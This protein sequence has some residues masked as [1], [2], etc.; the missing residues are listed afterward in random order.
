MSGLNAGQ[1]DA[2]TITAN[3]SGSFASETITIAAYGSN[4][5]G[6]HGD[7]SPIVVTVTAQST[8]S[9]QTANSVA[10]LATLIQEINKGGSLA[11]AN[12]NTAFI[13]HLAANTEYDLDRDFDAINLDAGSSLTIVGGE[14]TVINGEDAHH[15]FFL[16]N[17]ALTLRDLTLEHLTARGGDGLSAANV[18]GGGGA[19]LGGA[20][21]IAGSNPDQGLTGA[22]AVLDN[23]SFDQNAAVGGNGGFGGGGNGAGGALDGGVAGAGSFGQGG[24]DYHNGSTQ[25]GFGGGGGAGSIDV[26]GGDG[27][28]GGGGGIGEGPSGFGGYGG[29]NQGGGFGG[30]Q[31]QGGQNQGGYNPGNGGFGGQSQ[32]GQGGYNGNQGGQNQSQPDHDP[33]GSAPDAGGF[34][35]GA[36]DEPPF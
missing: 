36:G 14:G 5:S 1:S 11:V 31:G 12:P 35:G 18:D 2:L 10:D 3:P 28:F 4:A 24:A 33:W 7:L 29:G 32:G 30:G 17:G 34:S 9:D 15:G 16:L 23:V 19:G 22:S 20:L 21:F 6:Y 8:A 25:G 26:A 27:G 13:I